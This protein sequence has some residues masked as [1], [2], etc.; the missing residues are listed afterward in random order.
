MK[1]RLVVAEGE[2]LRRIVGLFFYLYRVYHFMQM[3]I[4]ISR[5]SFFSELNN[6]ALN[7]KNGSR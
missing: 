3:S 2:S 6:T 4:F 7:V 5:G 1:L